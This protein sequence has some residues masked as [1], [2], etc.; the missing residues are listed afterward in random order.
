MASF[1][2]AQRARGGLGRAESRAPHREELE[3]RGLC[4]RFWTPPGLPGVTGEHLTPV[5]ELLGFIPQTESWPPSMQNKNG[6]FTNLPQN[7]SWGGQRLDAGCC[8]LFQSCCFAASSNSYCRCRGTRT[9]NSRLP[10]AP[11]AGEGLRAPGASR[12]A[13]AALGVTHRSLISAPAILWQLKGHLGV[14]DSKQLPL[15]RVRLWLPKTSDRRQGKPELGRA[16]GSLPA[17]G[18][19][20]LRPNFQSCFLETY[21]RRRA[22]AGPGVAG[23][24][25]E[26]SSLR[27][28]QRALEQLVRCSCVA[29]NKNRQFW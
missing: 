13:P 28:E 27:A 15:P 18:W 21:W 7:P 2:R 8:F 1:C 16:L 19:P 29:Q 20:A 14:R 4:R 11:A 12:R 3:G 5:L 26:A 6:K 9:R 22:R 25:V 10:P 23:L 17:C 24:R